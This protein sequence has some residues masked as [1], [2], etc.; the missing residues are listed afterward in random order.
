MAWRKLEGELLQRDILVEIEEALKAERGTKVKVC[1]GSDSQVKGDI[2]D[3]ATAIV[4]LREG[5][6]GFVF[7]NKYASEHKFSIKERMIQEVSDS[8]QCAYKVCPILD[9][10]DTELE[11]HADINTDPNFKSNVAFKEAMGY[12]LGMGYTFKAKP[13]AFASTYCAGKV[14]S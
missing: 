3:F 11:V 12:I 7:V 10:Y 1:I 5:K 6:G 4:F 14:V 2:T 8:V 9:K 13:D